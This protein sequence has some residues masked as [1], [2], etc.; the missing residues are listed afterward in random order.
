MKSTAV[1]V[2]TV[3]IVGIV[4]VAAVGMTWAFGR[5]AT[6]TE[7]ES[8]RT[9]IAMCEHRATARVEESARATKTALAQKNRETALVQE[10]RTENEQLKRASEK[11]ERELNSAATSGPRAGAAHPRQEPAPPPVQTIELS[12]GEQR[13]MIPG[14][15]NLTVASLD[16]AS[17]EIWYGG[18]QRHLKVG[19][20]TT[21]SYLGRRCVLGLAGIKGGGDT[22]KASFT[23]AV[24]EPERWSAD[25][26]PA[27]PFLS[28]LPR[29]DSG[30]PE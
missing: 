28:R 1:T 6:R 18:H 19:E 7:L 2:S 4:L 13:D 16:P 30:R 20:S 29:S 11:R 14:V 23:F 8:L 27:M 5:A 25:A 12:R 9:R 24:M 3:G 15:L 17:A 22:Q 21:I 26:S 10:L